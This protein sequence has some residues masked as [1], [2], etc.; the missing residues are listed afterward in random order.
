MSR[1][2]RRTRRRVE[3]A[4]VT[5]IAVGIGVALGRVLLDLV[6][7]PP[8][9]LLELEVRG[10]TIKLL[11]P[12][13][14]WLAMAAPVIVWLQVLQLNDFHPVQRALNVLLRVGLLAALTLALARPSTSQY[15]AR[16]CTVWLVD[17]SESVPDEVLDQARDVVQAGIDARGTHLAR[18]VT[19]A[20]RP[21]VVDLPAS[22]PLAPL[23]R[24]DGDGAGLASDPSA[25]LRL[26]YG[27]CPQDHLKRVVVITDGNQNRGDLLAEAATAAEFGV[28]VFSHEIPFEPEPEVLVRGLDFDDNVRLNEPFTMMAEIW[29]NRDTTARISLT[30]NEFRDISGQ[31]VELT[32]G[33][34][35][36]PLEVEVYEPGFRRFTLT[37]TPDEADRFADNN[38]WVRSVTVEGRPRV[39][40]VEGENRSRSYL[41]RALDRERNDLAFFDLEVRGPWGFPTGLDEMANYDM[42]ILSDVNARYVSRTAM[43]NVE[44][45]VR[46]LGGGFLMVGGEHA[47]GPGGYD[48]TPLEDLSPVTFDMQRQRDMPSLA[49]ML[50]IDRSGSMSGQRLEMAKEAARAVVDTLGPQDYVGVVAFDDIP[51]TVVRLQ[52][53][54]NRSRIRSDIGR[55]GAGGGTDI[56]PALQEAYLEML[57]TPARLRLVIVLTDGQ[58]PWDGIADLASSM[59]ADGMTVSSVAVGRE[60]DSALLQMIAELGGG[61]FH[62]AADPNNVPRIFVQ[63]TSTVAR[64]NLVEEPFRAVPVRRSQATRGIDW[65]ASPYLL[66]Y[67]QTRP[68]S[69]AEVLLETERGDPL[70]ARWRRGLGRV[71]VF[72]SDLKNRWA[73]EWVRSSMYPRFWAQVVRDMMRI[74]SEETLAMDARVE[75]GVAVITVDAIDEADRFV[76]GLEST[77]EITRPDGSTDAIELEQIAAGRYEG[78]YRLPEFGPY[79]LSADHMRDGDSF[80]SSRGAVTWAYP[81]EYQTFEP[82]FDLPRRAAEVAGG[83]VD[84]DPSELWDPGDELREYRREWW[85]W[86]LFAALGLF[87]LDLLLRRVRMFGLRPIRWASVTGR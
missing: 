66:G 15:D 68:R 30:Q 48:G 56:F 83:H 82:D 81:D 57:S 55:I 65:D 44:R 61:R 79:Q 67:V 51:Q 77:V 12:G 33:Y 58:A 37:V 64:T 18:L 52:S 45:Y 4:V 42:I 10:E 46:D 78:R 53:A 41:Q 62:E 16:V 72:T 28:R 23:V 39:L 19:F 59:R 2:T 29:S 36:V 87:V 38:G 7:A 14:L 74:E 3:L 47:F 22:G 32:R 17:V 11:Q 21:R 20:E 40:Y 9:E 49:V 86:A 6:G 63:E 76:N 13:A 25:A 5:L 34:N 80:A 60:A 69:G 50:V 75:E 71:G 35:A 31:Q 8:V 54:S 26:S 1:W 43:Q 84:P 73:V 24:H 70:L 85:P 27:L